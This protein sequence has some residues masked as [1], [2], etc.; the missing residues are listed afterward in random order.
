MKGQ[1]QQER[2]ALERQFSA[3]S[4]RL[5]DEAAADLLA[6][7]ESDRTANREGWAASME[8]RVG[9]SPPAGA[10]VGGEVATCAGVE[11]PPGAPAWVML[12]LAG[13]LARDGRR[14]R[15]TNGDAVVNVTRANAG[16]LDLAIDYEH[17][18]EHA[19]QNGQPAAVLKA[20]EYRHLSAT[21]LPHARRCRGSQRS[22]HF[23]I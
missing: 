8:A 17:Q 15:L 6:A 19:K 13:Q 20:R 16:R 23:S 2:A 22:P 9:D 14:W 5:A 18:T 12:M 11:I 10:S 3:L 21:F 7:A 1:L 4:P